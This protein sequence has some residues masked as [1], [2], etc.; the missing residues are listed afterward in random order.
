MRQV[1]IALAQTNVTVG[2]LEGN[3]A[4]TG[5]IVAA[6]GFGD[7]DD[8]LYNAAALHSGRFYVPARCGTVEFSGKPL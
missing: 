7:R 8:D 3:A 5:E 4:Q 1:R 2:D 6:C